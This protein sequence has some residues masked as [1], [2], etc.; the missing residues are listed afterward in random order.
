MTFDE[1]LEDFFRVNSPDYKGKDRPSDEW[2]AQELQKKYYQEC[3]KYQALVNF[4]SN[5]CKTTI[6]MDN[7]NDAHKLT[8]DIHWENNEI[9]SDY[10]DV[11]FDGFVS[12]LKQGEYQDSER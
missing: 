4:L 7:L 3:R 5:N 8:I 10:S 12:L 11:I 6:G 2:Y 1:L 9:D